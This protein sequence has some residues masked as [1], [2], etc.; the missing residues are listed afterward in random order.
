M[1]LLLVLLPLLAAVLAR[2]GAKA[3]GESAVLWSATALALLTALLGWLTLPGGGGEPSLLSVWAESGTLST[4]ATLGIPETGGPWIAG[5]TTLMFLAQL[6]VHDWTLPKG[7]W[8]KGA[9]YRAPLASLLALFCAAGLLLLMA[10]DTAQLVAAAMLVVV[11]AASLT[12]F[13]HRRQASGKASQRLMVIC[14]GGGFALLLAVALTYLAIDSSDLA[15]TLTEPLTSGSISLWGVGVPLAGTVAVLIVVFCFAWLGQVP[16]HS[17]LRLVGGAPGPVSLVLALGVPALGL[18]VLTLLEPLIAP[19]PALN[20]VI[21]AIASIS[22]LLLA[23]MAFG[24][25]DIRKVMACLAAAL[26]GF[27]LLAFALV[28]AEFATRL[29]LSQGLCVALLIWGAAAVFQARDH[30]GIHDGEL[31]EMG[32]LKGPMPWAYGAMILGAAG[33]SGLGLPVSYGGSVT[34]IGGFEAMVALFGAAYGSWIF[35]V[36][37]GAAIAASAAAWRAVILAFLGKSRKPAEQGDAGATDAGWI[38]KTAFVILAVGI[39]GSSFL[40]ST[41]PATGAPDW[42]AALPLVSL[43]I[44]LAIAAL[45]AATKRYLPLGT[46]FSEGLRIE[47]VYQGLVIKPAQAVGS[48]ALWFDGALHDRLFTALAERLIPHLQRGAKSATTKRAAPYALATAIALLLVSTLVA[49]VGA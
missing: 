15:L 22:A 20:P 29:F 10:T 11:L 28:D 45:T 38:T 8:A 31:A 35:W 27:C 17:W 13:D 42:L 40:V 46:L 48:A 23:S 9:S 30:D 39:L 18:F 1:A 44:G 16:L 7:A 12:G 43:V 26:G 36:L 34:G 37:L 25:I 3:M 2:F 24:E 14:L 41:A 33:F 4:A 6:S 5:F 49:M 19:V 47:Q 32:G 21:A